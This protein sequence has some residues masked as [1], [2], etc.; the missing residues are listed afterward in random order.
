MLIKTQ[1][2]AQR[3]PDFAHQTWLATSYEP[4]GL[5]GILV[6]MDAAS[7]PRYS[8]SRREPRC[9]SQRPVGAALTS[10]AVSR[11]NP[12]GQHR[13]LSGGR[14]LIHG[15]PDRLISI[16][17]EIRRLGVLGPV[18]NRT[19]GL[20]IRKGF[21]LYKELIHPMVDYAC[22]ICRS[23]ARAHVR[24]LQVFQS[25]CLRIATSAPWYTGDGQFTWICE[26]HSSLTTSEP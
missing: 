1:A 8:T 21:L 23:I 6:Y 14:P 20:S 15:G 16:W 19:N 18:L 7:H 2:Q 13:P 17:S 10:T 12:L 26:L 9:S 11:A 4:G 25:K 24:K 3:E 22:P 5:A